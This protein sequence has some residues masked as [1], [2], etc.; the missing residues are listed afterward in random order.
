MA[1]KT[2]IIGGTVI[3]I[4]CRELG[5]EANEVNIENFEPEKYT[6]ENIGM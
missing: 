1:V 2:E 4:I 6:A 3:S 5:I